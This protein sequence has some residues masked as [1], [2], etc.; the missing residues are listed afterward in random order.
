MQ[1]AA[2]VSAGD[3]EGKEQTPYGDARRGAARTTGDATRL[4]QVFWN[5]LKNASKFTPKGGEIRILSRNEGDDIV[6]DITDNGIGFQ[7]EAGDADLRCVC[8]GES[9]D[10]PGIRRPRA[11]PG[12]FESNG[13]RTRRKH[14]GDQPGTWAGG[15]FHRA[16]PSYR[17]ARSGGVSGIRFSP[18]QAWTRAESASAYTKPM[19]IR[20]CFRH[21]L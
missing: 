1:H 10:Y 6:V 9:G 16:T 15:D 11:W 3:L 21:V 19:L 12:D 7:P 18:V 4:Q 5:L 13:R 2:E 14:H 20:R 17:A 8:A